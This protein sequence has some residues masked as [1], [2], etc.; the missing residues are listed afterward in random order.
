M[1]K[2]LHDS[3]E[4]LIDLA[5]KEDLA[6]CDV[7]S[8][9]IFKDNDNS[10]AKIIAKDTGV[11]CGGFV[12]EQV[13]S[14]IDT[15][16]VVKVLARD[17]DKLSKGTVAVELSGPTKSLLAGERISLNFIQRMSGIST[18]TS[19]FVELV[20]GTGIKILDTRKTLP[21]FRFI[22]KYSVKIG[23]GTNHR[24]GLFDMVMIKDNH[25]K[26]AGSITNAFNMVKAKWNDK[27]KIE[28]ETTNLD[29]VREAVQC[30]AYVIMLDNMDRPAMIEAIEIINGVSKI[31]ISGNMTADKI[32]AL[33]DLRIDYISLGALT[34]SVSAFDF[35]MK[36][37]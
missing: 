36:F 21:A 34:H 1:E 37:D 26:S 30:G 15:S 4:T 31:E 10:R 27:Y 20:D 12:V 23:G 17:G 5:I 32:I 16:V 9:A 22:D 28:I 33:K 7:T 6:G 35:S 2:N 14:K 25:I 8:E 11:F 29:E 24:I 13:Y 18:M 19:G 3:L